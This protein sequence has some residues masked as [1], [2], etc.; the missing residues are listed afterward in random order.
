MNSPSTSSRRAFLY[1]AGAAVALLGTAGYVIHQASKKP[2]EEHL[3]LEELTERFR[4]Q[5]MHPFLK[6]PETW[7]NKNETEQFRQGFDLSA[8][9]VT[10]IREDCVDEGI[11]EKV[12]AGVRYR[13]VP[14][15]TILEEREE[16]YSRIQECI[17]MMAPDQHHVRYKPRSHVACG[18]AKK[19][20][21]D[22]KIPGDDTDSIGQKEIL[23][24]IEEL[25]DLGVDAEFGGH[26]VGLKRNK[27]FHPA[28]M[29]VLSG[30]G[31]FADPESSGLP[32]SYVGISHNPAELAHAAE[33]ILAVAKSGHGYGHQL[34]HFTFLALQD[35]YGM[36]GDKSLEALEAVKKKHSPDLDVRII[37]WNA[38]KIA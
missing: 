23:T 6:D 35:R 8:V 20:A 1:Q 30:D 9:P 29:G 10:E 34:E 16:A 24:R 25:R 2:G 21:L 36:L 11:P 4:K 5:T 28:I 38:P 13:R 15:A 19:F 17:G 22:N 3:S 31:R 14:G 26:C 18:A 37:P 7:L 27:G 12:I 33:I 32:A